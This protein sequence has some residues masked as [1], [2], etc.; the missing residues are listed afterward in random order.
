[1]F[2]LLVILILGFLAVLFVAILMWSDVASG[3]AERILAE[4]Q[5]ATRMW[6]PPFARGRELANWAR[7]TAT[8]IVGKCLADKPTAATPEIGRA[9]V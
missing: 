9:H 4:R 8:Q 1:M 5:K 2:A 7:D 6:Q 3:N